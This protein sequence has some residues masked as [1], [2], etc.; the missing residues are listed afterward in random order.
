MRNYYDILGVPKNATPLEIKKRWRKLSTENHPDKTGGNKF[1]E[2]WLKHINEAYGVLKEPKKRAAHD[3][4]LAVAAANSRQ[5][6]VFTAPPVVQFDPT[7]LRPMVELLAQGLI[8]WMTE[9]LANVDGSERKSARKK[10]NGTARTT[11]SKG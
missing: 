1:L 8:K 10:R 6:A 9:K 5:Q 3:A 4:D 7:V 11:R 2:E